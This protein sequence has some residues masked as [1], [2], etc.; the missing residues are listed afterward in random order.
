MRTCC[1]LALTLCLLPQIVRAQGV[2]DPEAFVRDYV[3]AF[4]AGDGPM[5]AFFEQHGADTTPVEQR[6]ARY[7]D[8]R[9]DLGRLVLRRVDADRHPDIVAEIADAHGETA[10]FVFVLRA[11]RLEGIRVMRG[12]PEGAD[13][14][15][16]PLPPRS[17][18]AALDDVRRLV[19][20]AVASDAFS[21]VV[22]VAKAGG[23]PAWSRAVGE[24]D[25]D[26]HRP[27]TLDTSFNVGSIGK[28]FTATAVA[29][30]V[31][32]GK[33]SVDDTVGKLLPDYP[34]AT[35]RE[36]VTVRHLLDMRSGI[37][38]IFGPAY[39]RTD[40]STLKT[41]RDFLALFATEPL[42]FEP[43]TR[44]EYSN[45]GYIVLGLIV[46]AVTGQS[47]YDYVK[48]RIFD[49]AG[50]KGTGFL[51]RSGDAGGRATGYTTRLGGPRR[52]NLPTLPDRGSSAGGVYATAPDLVRYAGA[53]ASGAL[54]DLTALAKV[55]RDPKGLGIAGG[56]PGVNAALDTGVNGYTI[57]V[58]SNY[59]PPSAERLARDIRRVLAS[60]K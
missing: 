33:L 36:K 28:S 38:D 12:G 3:A 29:Q 40:K 42:H 56:A 48:A 20:A 59:D 53:L 55:G 49:P 32:A 26:A 45:G 43:G 15:G 9:K 34:N 25:K 58:L 30:L 57:V 35:V 5:R 4:N 27:N 8:L 1:A 18:S 41:L 46:E 14:E 54:V 31:A 52:S 39:E 60:V 7:G 2:T 50:M 24:A 19:D 17:E 21:G 23:A 11:G 22:L 37:G 51:A 13:A 16:P 6:M 10:T 44:R 47:Y